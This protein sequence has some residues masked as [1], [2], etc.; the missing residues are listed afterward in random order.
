MATKH[1]QAHWV[2]NDLTGDITN[3]SNSRTIAIINH[4]FFESVDNAKLIAA[5]PDLL[6]ALKISIKTAKFT[7]EESDIVFAAL[8]KANQ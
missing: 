8:R 3:L 7:K 5:A 2:V 6:E 4:R 1:T